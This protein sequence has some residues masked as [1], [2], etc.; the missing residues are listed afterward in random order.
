MLTDRIAILVDTNIWHYAYITPK[1]PEFMEIHESSKSFI[2]NLLLDGSTRIALS[3]YQVGEILE[4]FRK[5]GMG[6]NLRKELLEDFYKE[7]FLIKDL[8]PS[9]VKSCI[10][11]S[12]SSNIH[13][14]DYF[15]VLPLKGLIKKIYSADDHFQH[16]DF[17]SLAEVINPLSPWM[18]KE[19]C[20]PQKIPT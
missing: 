3:T 7:K 6:A 2:A 19:G 18:L 20:K 15:V 8:S 9:L 10:E 14:Y 16:Q 5:D 12:I 4:L 13:V 1:E 17:K 11:M